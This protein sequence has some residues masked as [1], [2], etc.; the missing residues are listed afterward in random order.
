MSRRRRAATVVLP[1]LILL[2]GIVAHLS[3]VA[4]GKRTER[5][6]LDRRAQQ[7]AFSLQRRVRSYGDV[8]YSVKGLFRGSEHVTQR[9]FHENLSSQHLFRRHPG[10]Q[11]V[12]YAEWA[13]GA[14]VGRLAA[15]VGREATASGLGYPGFAVRPV[16]TRSPQAPVTYIEPTAGNTAAFGFDFM[17]EPQRRTALLSTLESDKPEATAPVRLVQETEHQVGFLVMLGVKRLDGTPHG[18]AY[19]AFR[20]GDL[21]RGTS[22]LRRGDEL[23]VYDR[24]ADGADMA[25]LEELQPAFDSDGGRD[26]GGDDAPN[27]SRH[28]E[29]DVM[30]RCWTVYYAP[31]ASLQTG[32]ETTLEW[33]A[34]VLAAL[35]AAV[36]AWMLGSAQRTERRALALAERMTEHLRRSK[37]EL[38]RSNAE[39]ERFAYV[40]S[41]DLREPLRMVTG[42]LQLLRRR[43]RGRLDD[44]GRRVHRL[45]RRRR[46][47]HATA[48]RRPARATRA[49]AARAPLQPTSTSSAAW[50]VARPEPRRARSPR[51][52]ARV[53]RS[54]ALPDRAGRRRGS[55][56]SCS[57]TCSA[58]R[59]SSAPPTAPR[60]PRRRRATRRRVGSSRSPTTASAS[61]PRH[62]E[63]IFVHVPAPA[64]ARRVP[65][66]RHRPRHLQEG[67][68]APRRAHLGRER[69]GRRRALRLHAAGGDVRAGPRGA[70][71][72]RG[73]RT[74]REAVT[75]A[76]APAG[77]TPRC[78]PAAASS[79]VRPASGLNTTSP[80]TR[81]CVTHSSRASVKIAPR[82]ASV[83][84]VSSTAFSVC[85]RAAQ[86]DEVGALA[87]REVAA[88]VAQ[89][90]RVRAGRAW[91]GRADARARACGPGRG[92]SAR[93]RRR[94]PSLSRLRPVPAPT[95][96]PM[97]KRTPCRDVARH[98]EDPGGQ[99]RV[100][101]GAVRDRRAAASR[102][103]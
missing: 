68:R 39:L 95:S 65:G 24:G 57:R 46:H 12:G 1:A 36:C 78:P 101:G 9:E 4:A 20:M 74:R 31:A 33:L 32:V 62:A 6:R 50:C 13:A 85:P 70:R 16:P 14:G 28:V 52:G 81:T 55:S 19:A 69:G 18:A 58:T 59:S 41:H 77:I 80:A 75:R 66:H 15:R 96:V 34:L 56:A 90:E 23:E 67:R 2:A 42:Y 10:V 102:G 86:Q 3:L 76:A 73:V 89:A 54:G 103:V 92:P 47:A 53:D 93:G 35:L 8:L 99:E 22:G 40:A 61:T 100:A 94:A 88:R 29:I 48:D 30:G 82:L 7:V 64:H 87:R 72:R 91:P 43:Y 83:R 97:P 45:R 98:R 21:V 44:D 11:V 84:G 71:S 49:S 27:G 79:R 37:T 38:A 26:A 51:P 5:E 63:R 17:S 25:P 60:D